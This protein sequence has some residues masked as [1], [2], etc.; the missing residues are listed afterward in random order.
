MSWPGARDLPGVTGKGKPVAF[1]TI[2]GRIGFFGG[3]RGLQYD[4]IHPY[5][6]TSL[7]TI[8][9]RMVKYPKIIGTDYRPKREYIHDVLKYWVLGRIIVKLMGLYFT[10]IKHENHIVSDE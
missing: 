2:D 4:D 1:L 8:L 10:L 9:K 7:R 3:P 6:D 5:L